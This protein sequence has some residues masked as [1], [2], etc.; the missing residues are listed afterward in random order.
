MDSFEIYK[1][2][3]NFSLRESSM[4]DGHVMSFDE[5]SDFLLSKTKN[6]N[7]IK[8]QFDD[9]TSRMDALEK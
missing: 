9:M 2:L 1:T 6:K 8:A 5:F 3:A 7:N 4:G